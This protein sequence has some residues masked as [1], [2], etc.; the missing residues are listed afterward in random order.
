[1]RSSRGANPGQWASHTLLQMSAECADHSATWA[2]SV[3]TADECFLSVLIDNWM[4]KK[5]RVIMWE[6]TKMST[7]GS[8]CSQHSG[9]Y[10]LY[11]L[12]LLNMKRE[13][14]IELQTVEMYV[15]DGG[16]CC[17][18]SSCVWWVE[19]S[20]RC[21]TT[22]TWCL[23]LLTWSRRHQ[24]LSVGVEWSTSSHNSLA[25]CRSVTRTYNT[26]SLSAV[27]CT[28]ANRQF[29]R[30]SVCVLLFMVEIVKTYL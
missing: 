15:V 23:S 19:K 2:G 29:A 3:T 12:N 14:V 11:Y 7:A 18:C 17:C 13:R 30:L 26:R 16:G 27:L 8:L 6:W 24:P 4:N 10:L 20:F 1:M 22:W 5:T 21:P 25:G 9:M 28:A